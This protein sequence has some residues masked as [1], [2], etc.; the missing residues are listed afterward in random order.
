M[1]SIEPMLLWADCPVMLILLAAG[2]GVNTA[3]AAGVPSVLVTFGPAGGDMAA[4]KPEALLD[5]FA[6]LPDL[7]GRL[8][9]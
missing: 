7:V 9:G 3:S 4:L 2:S 5:S 1:D 6:D 8:I